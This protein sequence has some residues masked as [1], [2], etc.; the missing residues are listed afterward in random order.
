VPLFDVESEGVPQLVDRLDRA[1]A[2]ILDLSEPNA[3]AARLVGGD[4]DASVPRHSGALAGSR[5]ITVSGTGWGIAY[6]KPYAGF[7]HWGTRTM[8]ARPWL[9]RAARDAEPTWMDDLT[10]HV[11]KLL[12]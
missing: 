12:D 11:Q 3:Q 8:P 4:A 1:S 7:V 9:I 6:G 5:T 2:G 10:T